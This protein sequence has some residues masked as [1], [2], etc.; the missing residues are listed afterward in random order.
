MP[1]F[2]LD[3]DLDIGNRQADGAGFARA[4]QGVLRYHWTGLAQSI[5]L[6]QGDVEFGLKLLKDLRRQRRRAADANP[7]GQWAINGSIDQ[8][9]V[10]L[11]NTRQHRGLSSNN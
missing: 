1:R 2:V 5:A 11:R 7:Q 9:A 6:D 4:V 10:K 8:A 3:A